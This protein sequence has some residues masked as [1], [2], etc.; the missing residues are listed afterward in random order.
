M[1]GFLDLYEVTLLRIEEYFPDTRCYRAKPFIQIPGQPTKLDYYLQTTDAVNCSG[2]DKDGSAPQ[3]V[4][5]YKPQ[6]AVL[7]CVPHQDMAGSVDSLA[8]YIIGEVAT[9]NLSDSWLDQDKESAFNGATISRV[10]NIV[11]QTYRKYDDTKLTPNASYANRGYNGWLDATE[12]PGDYSIKGKN[13]R[14]RLDNYSV[15]I[16]TDRA[17]TYYDYV[18]GELNEVSLFKSSR[19]IFTDDDMYIAGDKTLKVSQMSYNINRSFFDGYNS[20]TDEEGNQLIKKVKDFKPRYDYME[21]H[22]S[23]VGGKYQTVYNPID[24]PTDVKAEQLADAVPVAFQSFLST[25]GSL[26]IT[27][28]K[29]IKLRHGLDF[30]YMTT[31]GGRILKEGETHV[32]MIP[33]RPEVSPTE[34]GKLPEGI[35]IKKLDDTT[36]MIYKSEASLEISPDGSIKLMDAWGSYILLSQGDIRIRAAS[37]IITLSETSTM[38]SAGNTLAATAGDLVE[39]TS[40]KGCII[41]SLDS[42]ELNSDNYLAVRT[43][44]IQV[45]TQISKVDSSILE[46]N[47]IHVGIG[48]DQA[49]ITIRGAQILS[50]GSISNA[51]ITSASGISLTPSTVTVNGTTY[52]SGYLQLGD[53][54]T[55]IKVRNNE[56]ITLPGTSGSCLMITDG[57]LYVKQNIMNQGLVSTNDLLAT[58]VAA[59]KSNEGKM[60]SIKSYSTDG[61]GTILDKRKTKKFKQ[62]Y[63]TEKALLTQLEELD[64]PYKNGITNIYYT[65]T[66]ALEGVAQ[67]VLSATASSCYAETPV[68]KFPGEHYWNATGLEV[69]NSKTG[70]KDTRGFRT[71]GFNTVKPGIMITN[72][73]KGQ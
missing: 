72:T 66:G 70:A 60:Y 1:A 43:P 22:G 55:T 42:I 58:S 21:A 59:A 48:S 47:S 14:V 51:V 46:I 54:P 32:N 30:M 10:P 68:Y 26:T 44:V 16:G 37:N 39:L 24:I 17:N 13:T 71:Y 3:V 35:E 38:M 31:N 36:D 64:M 15:T 2:P 33:I 49:S 6:A 11:N 52:M 28:I 67:T 45:K 9:P 53:Y 12:L 27:S 7:A 34:P 50:Y 19:T 61:V 4:R 25:D 73:K 18:L 63:Q 23:E 62:S 57:S 8:G 29:G 41:S 69:I 20:E 40:D 65:V 56:E 5:T